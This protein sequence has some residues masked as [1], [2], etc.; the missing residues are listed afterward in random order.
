M[1]SKAKNVFQGKFIRIHALITNDKGMSAMEFPMWE[2]ED[3]ILF[4]ENVPYTDSKVIPAVTQLVGENNVSE[5][6]IKLFP[7]DGTL[8]TSDISRY[9]F[10]LMNSPIEVWPVIKERIETDQFTDYEELFHYL[11]SVSPY[12]GDYKYTHMYH[13]S[14]KLVEK[15]GKSLEVDDSYLCGKKDIINVAIEEFKD[16]HFYLDIA[17][18]SEVYYEDDNRDFH[19]EEL[20]SCTS[21]ELTEQNGKLYISFIAHSRSE[22]NA[23]QEESLKEMFSSY[24][25][26]LFRNLSCSG[27]MRKAAITY[28]SEGEL[29]ISADTDN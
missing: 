19:V 13:L 3:D 16:S 18:T 7:K 23:K 15:D 10:V 9:I 25:R 5:H 26:L 29:Y 20:L 22:L 12:V 28:L 21:I 4:I 1:Y 11:L 27:H 2:G 8:T 6:L 14:G 17:F 24:A